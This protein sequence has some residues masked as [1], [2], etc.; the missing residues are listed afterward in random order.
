M[1]K[2]GDEEERDDMTLPR[3]EKCKCGLDARVEKEGGG[4]DVSKAEWRVDNLRDLE[5]MLL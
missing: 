2:T 5:R 4:Y 1:E 3:I